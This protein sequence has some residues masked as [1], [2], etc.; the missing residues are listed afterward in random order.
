MHEG[1]VTVDFCLP[2]QETNFTTRTRACL[3]RETWSNER[4]R[5]RI[6]E[7]IK[8]ESAIRDDLLS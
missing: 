5:A 7:H 2:Q 3:F 4:T 6:N 1:S 8:S